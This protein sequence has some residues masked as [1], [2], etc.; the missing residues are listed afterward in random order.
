MISFIVNYSSKHI[1]LLPNYF[2]NNL[3][4]LLIV[5]L[6]GNPTLFLNLKLAYLALSIYNCGQSYYKILETGNMDDT[7]PSKPKF[8]EFIIFF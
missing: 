2:F 4:L 7:I 3:N 5:F 1:P 8:N 6:T